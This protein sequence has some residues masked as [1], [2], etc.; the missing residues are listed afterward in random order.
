[1]LNT[2][3]VKLILYEAVFILPEDAFD[4]AG[5]P[6]IIEPP[7]STSVEPSGAI[8][9]RVI[10]SLAGRFPFSGRLASKITFIT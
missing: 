10:L 5:V 8:L 1:M 9:V 4:V 3:L 7:L 2:I 6:L